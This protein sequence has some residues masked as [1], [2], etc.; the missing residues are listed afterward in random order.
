MAVILSRLHTPAQAHWCWMCGAQ[1]L[2]SASISAAIFSAFCQAI[3]GSSDGIGCGE[4]RVGSAIVAAEKLAAA[5][6]FKYLGT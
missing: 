6:P 2:T 1:P 5:A 3:S 4:E